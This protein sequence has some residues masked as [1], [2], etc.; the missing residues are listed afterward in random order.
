M[1]SRTLTLPLLALSLLFLSGCSTT[2]S[3][4]HKP[5]WGQCAALGGA[6]W[7]IPGAA[8]SLATGGISLAAGALVSGLACAGASPDYQTHDEILTSPDA[9]DISLVHFEFDS[10]RLT[11]SSRASLDALVDRMGDQ[12]IYSVTG[13]SCNMGPAAYNQKLSERRAEA[14]KAYLIGK[15]VPSRQ[16]TTQGKGETE[17]LYP[18]DSNE[19]RRHNRRVEITLMP[20]P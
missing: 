9:D 20:H 10:D 8:H 1:T 11:D 16:I 4:G 2:G 3:S 15:G 12:G 18:N 5:G 6:I 7:G 17:P 19:N 13:H 14:V